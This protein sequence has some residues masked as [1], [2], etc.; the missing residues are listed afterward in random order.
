MDKLLVS[1]AAAFIVSL[2]V[3]IIL[4][5]RRRAGIGYF[6]G[7]V[8]ILA[9]GT[10]LIV[11]LSHCHSNMPLACEWV[12]VGILMIGGLTL[13][14]LLVYS[15]LA[16]G[17]ARA[18]R[19]S[20]SR[21]VVRALCQTLH[22]L[23]FL[24]GLA[25]AGGLAAWG[26]FALIQTGI[27]THW[28]NLGAL[29]ALNLQPGER[30]VEITA[31]GL[32]AVQIETSLGNRFQ[33]DL[34]FHTFPERLGQNFWNYGSDT[35]ETPPQ[36]GPDCRSRFWV[37]RPPGPVLQQVDAWSCADTYQMCTLYVL[38]ADGS[39]WVWHHEVNDDPLLL[40]LWLS[41]GVLGGL[42]LGTI[43]AGRA[44]T[45]LVNFRLCSGRKVIH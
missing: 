38:R 4:T 1:A 32:G 18:Q 17:I 42:L 14:M 11:P 2:G 10:W 44:H 15:L 28:H 35:F 9:Y 39:I 31:Y 13:A 43:L 30:V 21:P 7:L 16:L 24:L 34:D 5:V 6:L 3:D 23:I 36:R 19:G 27:P 20:A 22:T 8:P 25:S 26:I 12:G 40:P 29:S 37:A 41:P 45:R 33:T